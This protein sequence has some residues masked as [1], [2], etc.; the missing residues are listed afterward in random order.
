MKRLYQHYFSYKSLTIEGSQTLPAIVSL[1][2]TWKIPSRDVIINDL[3]IS[4]M[5]PRSWTCYS[6]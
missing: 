1:L 6:P 2:H 5:R 4:G 3:V